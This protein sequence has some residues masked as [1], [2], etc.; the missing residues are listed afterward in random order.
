MKTCYATVRLRGRERGWAREMETEG[1]RQRET[2]SDRERERRF[3]GAMAE[4]RLVYYLFKSQR[5]HITC[6]V[7]ASEGVFLF[8][9]KKSHADVSVL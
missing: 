4:I 1:G 9:K 3:V 5:R 8:F 2:Q 7:S 6:T